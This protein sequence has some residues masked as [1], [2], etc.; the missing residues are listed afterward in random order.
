MRCPVSVCRLRGVV[1]SHGGPLR[2][3]CLEIF[4]EI[5]SPNC[6]M[7]WTGLRRQTPRRLGRCRRPAEVLDHLRNRRPSS[8]ESRAS[9]RRFE[10][11]RLANAANAEAHGRTAPHLKR[12]CWI[13]PCFDQ[14][15]AKRQ[16]RRGARS[17]SKRAA[18]I[19]TDQLGANCCLY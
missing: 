6:P 1:I 8:N 14:A 9:W 19:R 3:K 16:H 2:L 18:T 7:D 12:R 17:Y 15:P 11:R 4:V 13:M 5:F 10:P